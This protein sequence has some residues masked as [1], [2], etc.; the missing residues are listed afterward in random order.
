M[1]YAAK[2][3]KFKTVGPSVYTVTDPRHDNIRIGAVRRIADKVWIATRSYAWDRVDL[4]TTY[5]TR[6]AAAHALEIN[7]G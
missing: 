7:D 1:T 5:T 2:R 3:Y 6:A 4:V